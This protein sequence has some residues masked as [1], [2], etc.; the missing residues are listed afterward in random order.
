MRPAIERIRAQFAGAL[1]G[2][3]HAAAP[4]AASVVAP[5]PVPASPLVLATAGQPI[6]HSALRYGDRLKITFFES[7]GV[8]VGV[9]GAG[10]DGVVATM[11][12]RMDISADYPVDENGTLA[13]PKLGRFAV[14][15]QSITRLQATLTASFRQA[16]GR[17]ADVQ[18]AIEER[19]PVSVLGAVRGAGVF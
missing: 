4:V 14:A 17:A 7:V 1:H 10:N 8:A 16:M 12:P 9:P 13:I 18:I 3:S 19:Q 15:G 11:F 6:D 2:P 5:P